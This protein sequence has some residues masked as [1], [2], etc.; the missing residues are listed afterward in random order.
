M[1]MNEQE[2]GI[3]DKHIEALEGLMSEKNTFLFVRP[4]EYDSTLLIKEG[5]ATKSMDIHHKSSNWG[6]MAG[7]VPCDPAF[8]KKLT[9]TPDPQ[10]LGKKHGKS[11]PVQLFL[12][13]SLLNGHKKIS[14]EKGYTLELD[15]S[16]SSTAFDYERFLVK[17]I[18]G[19]GVSRRIAMFEA[20]SGALPEHRFVRAHDAGEG[21]NKATV[22]CLTQKGDKWLVY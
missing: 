5:Y 21:G 11:H 22:F 4:T 2:S 19:S 10:K 17:P 16:A 3:T 18:A 12:K 14:D 15:S 6:P 13:P 20:K 8:S 9:G 1:S 7:F